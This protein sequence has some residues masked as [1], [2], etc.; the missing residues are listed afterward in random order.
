MSSQ[1]WEALYITCTILPQW[2][3]G[4]FNH[5]LF[6]KSEV[7]VD[8]WVFIIGGHDEYVQ[9]PCVACTHLPLSNPPRKLEC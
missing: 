7:L 2:R 5:Q 3:N 8:V 6:E 1:M 9:G 4:A